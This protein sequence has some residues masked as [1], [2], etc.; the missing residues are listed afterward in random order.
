WTYKGGSTAARIQEIFAQSEVDFLYGQTVASAGDLNG[1]GKP[2]F[3]VGAPGATVDGGAN[4]GTIYVYSGAPQYLLFQRSG[5]TG[6]ILGRSVSTAGDVNGDG[7][8]D[9][10][11]GALASAFVYSG[12]PNNPVIW[13]LNGVAGEG[14]GAA[15]AGIGDVNGD[16]HSDFAVAAP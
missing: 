6:K 14:F 7:R 16:G 4:A 11:V 1:D 15:V 8:A 9:I 12:A 5:P 3:I 10:I 13:S 2:D